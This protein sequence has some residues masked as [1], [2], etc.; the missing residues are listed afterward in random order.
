MSWN[1]AR[2]VLVGARATIVFSSTVAADDDDDHSVS[3]G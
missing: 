3:L 2:R 1:E